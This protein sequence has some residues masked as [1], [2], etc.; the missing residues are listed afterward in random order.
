MKIH[1]KIDVVNTKRCV[2]GEGPLWHERLQL[3]SW[4]DIS[5]GEI[6]ELTPGHNNHRVIPLGQMVGSVALCDS[7]DYIAG[8]ENGIAL[9]NRTNGSFQI[10]A[11]PENDLPDNRFNDG[12][13]DPEG[14]FWIGSMSILETKGAGTVYMLQQGCLQKR[15]IGTT[16]SNGMAWS[17]DHKYFYYIDT[18][19]FQVVAYTYDI[20][21]GQID[22]PK[23]AINIPRE[24]GYPDGM[25]V[26]SEGMLWIAL[27]SGW[28]VSR[29]NP[30]TGERLYTL[31]LPV[32]L[33]TSCIFGGPELKDLYI[34][35]AKR[36][37]TDEDLKTQP[38]A[39]CLFVWK[40]SSYQG[41]PSYEYHL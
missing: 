2:L 11:T 17:P 33:V 28:Q 10:I 30:N 8:L 4:V 40:N 32:S 13:V 25:T 41:L 7:G 22:D 21:T 14:R 29:W 31:H 37:L 16:I 23:V 20:E 5:N 38:L 1:P 27:W 9:I 12:K 35:T 18:A 3:L 26:D 34:T 36:G 15:I 6:H 39:G 24:A 19:T